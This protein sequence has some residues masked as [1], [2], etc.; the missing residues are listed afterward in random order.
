M[1]NL[2]AKQQSIL[3][4]C[5]S[6][7]IRDA[8]KRGDL[9]DCPEVNAR[10][11]KRCFWENNANW[12]IGQWFT[13]QHSRQ[14]YRGGRC[15]VRRSV[16]PEGAVSFHVTSPYGNWCD[17]YTPKQAQDRLVAER[18]RDGKVRY[19]EGCWQNT[20]MEAWTLALSR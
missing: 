1:T 16:N 13:A 15:W 6:V 8:V 12:Q 19:L 14:N 4:T 9:P 10:I 5:G 2:T 11:A 7:S 17:N 3:N 18:D 20:A